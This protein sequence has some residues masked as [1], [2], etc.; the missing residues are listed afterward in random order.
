MEVRDQEAAREWAA[1]MLQ[2]REVQEPAARTRQDR[3]AQV[4]TVAQQ[5]AARAQRDQEVQ[6]PAAPQLMAVRRQVAP[7]RAA[8]TR[9][10]PAAEH[11]SAQVLAA[12]LLAVQ[13]RVALG[14]VAPKTAAHTRQDRAA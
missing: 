9:Q 5:L 2:G 11:R 1:R 13:G 4:Q 7:E 3:G 6:G 14:Q 8:R 12:E 10:V